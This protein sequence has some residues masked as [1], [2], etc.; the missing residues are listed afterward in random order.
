[1]VNFGRIMLIVAVVM[2]VGAIF[3]FSAKTIVAQKDA[4]VQET[5][6]QTVSSPGCT[7]GCA[8]AG[9]GSAEGGCGGNCAAA[10]TGGCGCGRN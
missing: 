3:A 5:Q 10:K 4:P 8:S 9:C 7:G 6:T 2:A 1:M